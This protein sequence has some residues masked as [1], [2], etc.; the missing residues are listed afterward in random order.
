MQ[1]IKDKFCHK[2]FEHF[3]TH[4]NGNTSLCCYSWL[5]YYAGKL[6][7]D[8]SVKDVFNSKLVQ[9][10]RT[11][12]LN[13]SFKYCNH[14]LCPHIQND[15]L[16]RKSEVKNEYLKNIIDNDIINGL[17][18]RFYNLCYDLSC[19]LS[20][21]SCRKEKINHSKGPMY[22]K[23]LEIQNKI[24]EEV[25]GEPNEEYCLISVTG[26]GDPFGSK[27]FREFLF[28]INGKDFPNVLFNLQTNGVMFTP[29]Y[30]D[31]MRSI[32]KN[33]NTVIV[34]YD[35]GTEKTYNITRRGG[36]WKKLQENM[37]FLSQLREDNKIN[38]LRIDFVV[39]KCNYKEIPTVIK[40]GKELNVDI[41]YFSKIINWGTFNEEEFNSHAVWKSSHP[42]FN[43]YIRVMTN[44]I[45]KDKIVDLGNLSD[46]LK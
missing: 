24:I 10:I 6:D 25:F 42:E 29:K 11:S 38:E 3:E 34:S 21:P 1:K 4:P 37:R 23:A 18:P 31:K 40:I 5:P 36:N 46:N 27:L 20:C 14:K 8:M 2:P 9:D 32:Q 12:I 17:K 19:N 28:S 7:K 30:W 22:Q 39:Q 35:A 15:S 45:L 41:V 16:P 33:I 44:P 26:S 13:G 43:D